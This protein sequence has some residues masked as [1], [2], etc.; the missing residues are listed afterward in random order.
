[1]PIDVHSRTVDPVFRS[2][3]PLWV[4]AAVMTC[5]SARSHAQT[6]LTAAKQAVRECVAQVRQDATRP[7]N[8][9]ELGPPMWKNFDAYVSPDGRVH[10]NARRV[11]ETEGEYRFQKCIAERGFNLGPVS[12][13]PPK[14][15]EA[16]TQDELD[17]RPGDC[18]IKLSSWEKRLV[19]EG[20]ISGWLQSL[21]VSD[22]QQYARI[23]TSYSRL[24][25]KFDPI[26]ITGYFDQLYSNDENHPIWLTDALDLAIRIQINPKTKDIPGLIALYRKHEKPIFDGYLRKFLPP[27]KV[28]ISQYNDAARLPKNVPNQ[29]ITLRMLG[30]SGKTR[31]KLA[32][33]FMTALLNTKECNTLINLKESYKYFSHYKTEKEKEQTKELYEQAFYPQL[34]VVIQYPSNYN[35]QTLEEFFDG[36]GEL[37]GIV[38]LEKEQ[39]V[40]LQKRGEFAHDV[41][42]DQLMLGSANNKNE[43]GAFLLER[44]FEGNFINLNQYLVRNGLQTASQDENDTRE[45]SKYF[46][47]LAAQPVPEG[48]RAIL[49]VGTAP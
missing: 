49:S 46:W 35:A 34:K 8:A 19:Y 20:L 43:Y 10:N 29:T 26:N 41:K 47:L 44:E 45:S 42:L 15:T 12:N 6:D 38:L 5:A 3:R 4:I 14:T 7:E 18:W 23:G 37:S 9:T 16:C 40:C 28:V 33:E 22:R 31:S 36:N 30:V 21:Q 1:M 17:Y 48:V 24:V 13:G 2:I 39:P 25:L 11:G 27:N 32:T